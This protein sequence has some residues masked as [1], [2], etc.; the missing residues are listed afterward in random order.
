[1]KMFIGNFAGDDVTLD[2]VEDKSAIAL[3]EWQRKEIES[4]RHDSVDASMYR[5]MNSPRRR[6]EPIKPLLL[7]IRRI[8]R[9][10]K[11]T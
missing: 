2:D 7:L 8:I 10:L 5:I 3:I 1:M 4:M 6:Q 11:P 9:S